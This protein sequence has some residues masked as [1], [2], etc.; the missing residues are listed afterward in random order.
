MDNAFDPLD[1]QHPPSDRASFV[2]H[3]V[4]DT[5]PELPKTH[6][7]LGAPSNRWAY[8]DAAG[9]LLGYVC[10]FDLDDGGK[11]FR[12]LFWGRWQKKV[13][14]YWKA[15]GAPRSLYNLHEVQRRSDALII[16]TE[17]EKAADAAGKIFLDLVAVSPMNGAKS[18]TKADWSPL[19][20]RQVVI[21]GD[22]DEVGD[23]FSNEVAGLCADIGASSIRQVDLPAILPDKWD[24]AEL[25][26]EGW[27]NE[28]LRTLVDE[29]LTWK[30][31]A[32][33]QKD[34]D[35]QSGFRLVR[36]STPDQ[37]PGVYRRVE[38]DEGSV[39]WVWF[40]SPLEILADTRD[41]ENQSWGRL[42]RVTDRD[43]KAHE[44]PMP[45]AMLAGDGIDYRKT[46]LSLGLELAP[47]RI[48]RE[49]HRLAAQ[50]QGAL[51]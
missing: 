7:Q 14:W 16:I 26:P 40:C 41:A 8:R 51:R 27:T 29:S 49:Y 6:R 30:P 1:N 42:L 2:N 28:T 5:S 35:A 32:T 39:S 18:P 23:G 3:P 45:M 38:D 44:W 31:S 21:W 48:N 13:G 9:Q 37:K 50:H 33:A 10:R 4:P 47:A 20:G 15:P 24:L 17:G 22:H 25:L 43:S 19:K 46:L 11:E 12:P 36:Q 34:A